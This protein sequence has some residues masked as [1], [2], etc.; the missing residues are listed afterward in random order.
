MFR[1]GSILLFLLCLVFSSVFVPSSYAQS[2]CANYKFA[3]NQVFTCCNDLPYLNSS[4]HWNYD[5]SSNTVEIAYRHT[6]ITSSRWVAWAINPTGLG[7]LGAQSLAAFHKSDGTITVYTAPVTHC[8][9]EIWVF[10]SPIY[11]PLF[12]ETRSS[13]LPRSS[14]ITW[15]WAPRWTRCGKRVPCREILRQFIQWPVLISGPWGHWI[16]FPARPGQPPELSAPIQRKRM[17]VLQILKS[18]FWTRTAPFYLI[19]RYN[20]FSIKKKLYLWNI[21]LVMTLVFEIDSWNMIMCMYLTN[22]MVWKFCKP[23][24]DLGWQ[25]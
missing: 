23:T 8:R 24:Y 11:P 21:W 3:T 4:L 19:A 2:N 9:R 15:T 14:L 6:G 13:S 10:R 12:P 16:F 1:P 7:M 5:H 18:C 17:W 22:S 20:Y 25:K